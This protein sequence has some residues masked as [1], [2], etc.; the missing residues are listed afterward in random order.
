MQTTLDKVRLQRVSHWLQRQVDRQRLAGASVLIAS[1]DDALFFDAHGV[2]G[3]KDNSELK[4]ERRFAR[5]TLV[6]LYSMTK[7]VT[8]A[9]AL[10]LFE[11]GKFQLD[12]PLSWYLPEFTNLRVWKGAGA[13]D[14][15][16]ALQSNTEP[17][18]SEI[19]IRQLMTHTS[20]LTYSFMNANVVD[21]YYRENNLVF[22]GANESLESMINRLADAPLV[23]QPGSAWHY[24]VSTDVLGRLVEIW[25][26]QRLD[27]FFQQAIF[28]PL[29]MK[30]TGFHVPANQLHRFADLYTP[31][32]GGDLGSLSGSAASPVAA[33]PEL[34]V[35]E[36]PTPVDVQMSSSFRH[37]PALHSGGGGLVGSIDDYMRFS[38]MLLNGGELQGSRLLGRKTAAFMLSNQLPDN[39]DMASMGQAVW[40]ETSYQGIG[41]A[42]GGAVVID[43]VKAGLLASCGEYHWGGAASTFFWIDPVEQLCTVFFTQ[44]Y[45]SSTYPLR[46]ELR[47]VINQALV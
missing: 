25:S 32:A 13:I 17:L 31:A 44:L 40:S 45:P 19:S 21:E 47:T 23:C 5:D 30:D 18:R 7:P 27:E 4:G 28:T 1:G 16:D 6:R 12:D 15:A 43:P 41:F 20:G 26:G 36:P 2:A 46:K 10:M 42:L 11:Q 34:S 33:A 3:H 22:P 8:T 39:A 14:S 35:H 37:K 38:Q 29:R 24:S 9:A